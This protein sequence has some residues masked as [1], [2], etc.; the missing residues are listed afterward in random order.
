MPPKLDEYQQLCVVFIRWG[1]GVRNEVN[2]LVRTV[3]V[4]CLVDH[5]I[6]CILLSAYNVKEPSVRLG[7]ITH[8][9]NN[10]T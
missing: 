6:L 1:G 2:E 9:H 5:S 3:S 4:H 8:E 7:I 10:L